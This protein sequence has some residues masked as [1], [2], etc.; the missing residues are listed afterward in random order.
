MTFIIDRGF[1]ELQILNKPSDLSRKTS[2]TYKPFGIFD[3]L[4]HTK[5]ILTR[6]SSRDC[7]M[8][9]V[10]LWFND[11]VNITTLFLDKLRPKR[12]G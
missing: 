7:E 9:F 12:S 11:P 6:A 2:R 5:L 8:T 1:A 3:K 4:L 10:V